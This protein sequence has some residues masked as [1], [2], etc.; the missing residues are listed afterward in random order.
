[1]ITRCVGERI[2]TNVSFHTIPSLLSNTH[3]QAASSRLLSRWLG[4]AEQ[5]HS[6]ICHT[7][8]SRLPL[9]ATALRP[10]SFKVVKRPAATDWRQIFAVQDHSTMSSLQQ[11]I[12]YRPDLFS[13]VPTGLEFAHRD[14]ACFKPS[15]HIFHISTFIGLRQH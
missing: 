14:Q 11:L 1:M 6:K 7:A 12:L 13:P 10:W 3:T 5:S 15:K 8:S 9:L 2:H 4:A